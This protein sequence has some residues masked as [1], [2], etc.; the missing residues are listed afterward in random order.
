MKLNIFPC[1]YPLIQAMFIEKA[2]LS[3]LDGFGAFAKNQ[4]AV[5]CGSLLD[6]T[7]LHRSI[8]QPTCRL[9]AFLTAL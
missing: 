6:C 4:T 2:F 8:R 1:G 9:R 5:C 7:L 3:S